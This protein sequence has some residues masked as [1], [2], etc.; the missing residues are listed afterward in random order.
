MASL[1]HHWIRKLTESRK[2]AYL[3]IPELIEEDLASG[4]LRPRDRLPGLRDLA[5]ELQLNY[6]TVARAYAEARKRGLLDSR[7]GSGTFV[8][9]RTAT[10]PLSG[11]SSVEMTMNMPPEPA[12]LA[13]RLRD[14]AARLFSA[15]DPYR[16][17]RY[18]DFGG[19]ADDRAAGTKWLKRRFDDCDEDKVLVC[20]GIHSA[21]VA[22][23]S[24]LARPGG[25]IC[26]DTLAYPGIKAIAAQLGVRLQALAR[27]DDGPLAHA[28]EALCK[29]DKPS[30]FYCNPT[31]QNPSTVT[32]SSKRREA[33]AD[34]ALRYSVPII[35]DDAYG[36]L[37]VQAPDSLAT[38]APDLTYYV[39]G[40][41]KSFGAGLRVAYIRAPSARR[42]QHLAGALRATTV[43]ASPF[44]VLLA[45]QW[46][47]DGTADLML[48]AI[49]AE[50]A[51]RQE[52]AAR[53]L[54]GW[55]FDADPAGFHLWMPIAAECGWNAS[56][57]ALQLRS[58]GIGAVSAAAFATDGNPPEAIRVCLGGPKN[59][60]ECEDALRLIADT[61]EHP[62]HLHLP[63]M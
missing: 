20:P 16:L 59:L 17:L 13:A 37:P 14:S 43:M 8:R 38:L 3:L 12:E 39:T 60:D 51:A 5:D 4:R 31:I 45:T 2:P 10:L 52:L 40:F 48:D 36:M 21:L 23:V 49:R 7:A 29:S 11:G 62:H 32:L 54:S 34:V 42:S 30:A 18:Q 27:D 61:V 46:V 33:L 15:T 35:E 28:F 56:E 63:V 19:T 47:N 9:G 25:T 41:S 44:T 55:K 26:L 6:T 50:S 24:Q 1:T 22:L 53:V 57:L 58:Q